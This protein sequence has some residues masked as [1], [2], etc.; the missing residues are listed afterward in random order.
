MCIVYDPPVWCGC[1]AAVFG[2]FWCG[3][4]RCGTKKLPHHRTD[5]KIAMLYKIQKMTID[6]IYKILKFQLSNLKIDRDI[7]KIAIF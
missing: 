6:Q 7:T 5:Q 3:A 1:G 2:R 4:V